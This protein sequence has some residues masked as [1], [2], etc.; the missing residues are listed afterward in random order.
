MNRTELLKRIRFL[1]ADTDTSNMIYR[2]SLIS[3]P[4]NIIDGN[5]KIFFLLNRRIANIF[6]LY[7]EDGVEIPTVDYTLDN[8]TGKL[9]MG[10]PPL[11]PLYVDYS[12]YKLTDDEINNAIDLSASSGNFNPDNVS[13]GHL[14]Y[15]TH[16]VVGYC[17][18]SAASRAAE[19][20]TLSA[21]GKQV[22]KSELFNHYTAQAQTYLS[23]AQ[24]FRQD[25][26]TSRG[27][28][29]IPSDAEGSNDY[30]ST[31]Y[32]PEDGGF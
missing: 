7:D 25:M 9:I 5:N 18:E 30:I 31:P 21:A 24:S 23:Q 16:Y 28:R 10:T 1:F 8:S 20:Y 29:D 19:Y 26:I 15:V 3:R 27:Q 14:D 4:G 17:F 12:W 2:E 6:L 22:S 32:F 11:R 13:L